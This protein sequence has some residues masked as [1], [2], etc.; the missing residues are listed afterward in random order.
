MFAKACFSVLFPLAI[1]LLYYSAKWIAIFTATML[2]RFTAIFLLYYLAIRFQLY[3]MHLWLQSWQSNSKTSTKPF[4]W[5]R[6][7]FSSYYY[8]AYS[9][10]LIIIFI[11]W[12]FTCCILCWLSMHIAPGLLIIEHTC[13][14]RWLGFT[15]FILS[16]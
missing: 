4:H 1:R 2:Y 8:R 7:C 5:L 15:K 16:S 6:S 10:L 12:L 9:C 3:M 14:L 13:W 11:L